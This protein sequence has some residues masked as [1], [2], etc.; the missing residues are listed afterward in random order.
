MGRDT[1]SFRDSQKARER[2]K[3]LNPVWRGVGCLLILVMAAGGYWFAEWF[4][5]ANAENSWILIPS[6]VITTPFLP[7]WVPNGL[8]VKLIVGFLF[9]LFGF[10]LLSFVYAILFPIQPGETDVPQLSRRR[11]S[12]ERGFRSRGR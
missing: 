8:M 10:G 4:L 6:Q 2:S 12:R 7:A 3:E 5:A 11:I 9:M 1:Y